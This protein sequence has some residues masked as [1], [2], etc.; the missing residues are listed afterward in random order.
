MKLSTDI[1]TQPFL[2]SWPTPFSGKEF[3]ECF[4]DSK[5]GIVKFE[6]KLDRSLEISTTKEKIERSD[7]LEF[8]KSFFNNFY[9]FPPFRI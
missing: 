6:R 7:F 9:K 2:T 4:S 5:K 8:L 3:Q 1:Y